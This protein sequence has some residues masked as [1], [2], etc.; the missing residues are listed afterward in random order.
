MRRCHV[1]LERRIWLELYWVYS[2]RRV[3][4]E[5]C[6]VGQYCFS[7]K[8][9]V[10]NALFK[11]ASSKE[12]GN[13]IVLSFVTCCMRSDHHTLWASNYHH[14]MKVWSINISHIIQPGTTMIFSTIESFMLYICLWNVSSE[15]KI[16]YWQPSSQC[17]S[18]SFFVCGISAS[19]IYDNRVW[20]C[21]I[22]K[23]TQCHLRG[24]FWFDW[25]MYGD[26]NNWL[27]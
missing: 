20:L 14:K 18:D 26:S 27:R 22:W 16:S 1:R 19:K 4:S 21:S 6:F 12:F 23:N 17:F 3:S 2:S 10:Y 9:L 7:E 13:T 11:I 8:V 24:T 15:K 5:C 25:K